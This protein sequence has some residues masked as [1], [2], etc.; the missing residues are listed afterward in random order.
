MPFEQILYQVDDPIATITLN[1]PERLNAWTETMCEEL[2]Q[3]FDMADKDDQVRAIIVTGEG[4]AFCAGA[5]LDPDGFAKKMEKAA[6]ESDE[7][8]RDTAGRVT[9]RI[10]EM[11]KP[12]IAA[13]N[14]PAVG[15][16][17][18]LTLA[19]D[20]RFASEKAKIGFVFN[21]RGL[22]PEGCSTW[23]LSR[24]MGFSQAAEWIYTG[25]VL[26]PQ[27]ALDGKLVSRVLPPDELL[28]AAKA[29]AMEIA[30]NTSAISTALS[31]SMLWQ[32]MCAR[33]PMEAHRIESRALG[34]MF[35]SEDLMEGINS[36][37]EKRPAEFKMKPGTDMPDFYPWWTPPPF[38]EED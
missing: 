35:A 7:V 38:K 12:V 23:F 18:T 31:R 4:K 8:I 17:A 27:E 2:I 10:F 32:M 20:I 28:P 1:R 19:M 25:R 13:I 21:R 6:G 30:E 26:T 9:L 34:H 15:V 37:L 16:G 24:I 36:F 14:G 22:V 29:L 33:H 11:K 5:D 3:A